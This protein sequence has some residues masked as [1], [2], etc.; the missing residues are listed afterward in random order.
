MSSSGLFGPAPV[1]VDLSENQNSEI[2]GAVVTLM[3]LSTLFIIIRIFT[4]IFARTGG[5]AIDDYL[6]IVGWVSQE[7]LLISPRWHD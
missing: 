1:G 2:I 3:V 6:I 4:R 7:F 5:M